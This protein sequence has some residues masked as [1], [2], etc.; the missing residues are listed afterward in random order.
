MSSGSSPRRAG[1]VSVVLVN[2]RGTDDT[3][4]AVD[5]LEEVDWN[6][7]L[8]EIIVVENASG[9]DSAARLR[10]SLG[11]R[12]TLVESDTNRGFTG[13]CNLGVAH[14]TGE[15]VAFLNNDAK[16]DTG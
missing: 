8:L 6:R 10:A 2:F 13:G 5:R 7:D 15:F 16:P 4:E 9:D 3:I 14:T 12:I 1:V 11:D